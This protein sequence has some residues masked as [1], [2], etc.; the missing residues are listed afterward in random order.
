[1]WWLEIMTAV[2]HRSQLREGLARRVALANAEDPVLHR[3]KWEPD[4]VACRTR[5]PL[6]ELAAWAL[7]LPSAQIN[8]FYREDRTPA[9]DLFLRTARQAKEGR[10][11]PAAGP[12]PA[13]DPDVQVIGSTPVRTGGPLRAARQPT[14]G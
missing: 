10:T 2:E 7:T 9:D 3:P 8:L 1:M 6:A 14:E 12:P 4:T 13:P 5:D 11:V